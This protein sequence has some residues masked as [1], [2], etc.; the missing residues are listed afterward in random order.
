MGGGRPKGYVGSVS[1]FDEVS[2]WRH[3]QFTHQVEVSSARVIL[4]VRDRKNRERSGFHERM[5]SSGVI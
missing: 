1:S 2:R 4:W 3:K 5:V